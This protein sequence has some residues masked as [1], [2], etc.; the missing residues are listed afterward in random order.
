ML[1]ELGKK[2]GF[3]LRKRPRTIASSVWIFALLL[4]SEMFRLRL[5]WFWYLVQMSFQPLVLLTFVFFLWDDPRAAQFA[6]TGSLVVT[7]SSSAML[8][9]GQYIGWMKSV[10]TYEH[11][12]ALP[13]SRTVFLAAIATRGVL[14]ALPSVLTVAVIGSVLMDIDF[15]FYSV[16]VLLLGTYAM[17]G[18]GAFIGFWSRDAQVSSLAT[19]VL[20][21]IIIFL[22]PVYIPVERLPGLLQ[23]TAKAIPTTYVA[24]ALRL[25]VSGAPVSS[26]W[27]D[28]ALLA[29]LSLV[30]LLLVPLRLPWRQ[31]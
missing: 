2:W 26:I 21:T 18:L 13:I 8:S 1:A 27:P 30:S 28:I 3:G 6:V 9:L 25:T 20:S 7:M 22:A 23:V 15:T 16:V 14:L 4:L 19:Q 5:Q 17:S 12:A 29:G 31:N 11:Y 10:N 24:R